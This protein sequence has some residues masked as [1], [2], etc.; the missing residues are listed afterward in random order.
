MKLILASQSAARRTML[1]QAG[2]PF[3]AVAPELDEEAAKAGLEGAGFEPRGV[4]EELAQ[5]KALSIR[6][7]PSDLVLG[8]DQILE[9]EDGEMLSKPESR[10]E[11][12]DQLRALSGRTHFLHSAA[13]I[14]E[15]GEGVWWH[16]ET[17]ELAMR[18]LSD[19][20]LHSYLDREYEAIRWSVGGYRIEGPGA[21]LFERIDGSYFAVL[22]MPLLPLL[23]YLRERGVL[24]R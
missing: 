6:A 2:V 12:F 9:R 20:F 8:S 1:E 10:E 18:T 23:D 15:N 14:A 11:A 3:E 5:L 13:V 19:A 21:Q 7:G 17:A 16:S 4:A 22:G 24:E